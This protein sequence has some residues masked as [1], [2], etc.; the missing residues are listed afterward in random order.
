MKD[1]EPVAT[2][3]LPD[4]GGLNIDYRETLAFEPSEEQ[5]EMIE[6]DFKAIADGVRSHLTHQFTVSARI[7]RTPDGLQGHVIVEFPT[8]DAI[9]PG[10]PILSDRF[11]NAEDEDW[12][13]PISPEEIDEMTREITQTTILQWAKML[14]HTGAALPA[15]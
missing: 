6:A 13:G 15:S 9:G 4:P 1:E 3:G 2:S 10:I 11:E 8:G 7:E 14:E 5:L 12:Q